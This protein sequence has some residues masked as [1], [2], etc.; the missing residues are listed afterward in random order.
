[1]RVPQLDTGVPQ[2]VQTQAFQGTQQIS[3]NSEMFGGNNPL[4]SEN[5]EESEE[6]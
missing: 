1:M 3:V 2:D 5:S 4:N 6:E